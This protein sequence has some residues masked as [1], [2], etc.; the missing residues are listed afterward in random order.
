MF[1]ALCDQLKY[2]KQLEISHQELREELVKYLREHPKMSDGTELASF[3]DAD[4]FPSWAEYLRKMAQ[5]E[6]GDHIILSAAANWSECNIH[7]IS[8]VPSNDVT[9][10]PFHPSSYVLELGHVVEL[11]YVSLRRPTSGNH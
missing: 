7:V 6:W 5:D 4:R 9:I 3:L 11:H 8:S 1:H 2:K 10:S